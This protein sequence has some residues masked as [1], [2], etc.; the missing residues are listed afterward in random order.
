M[1]ATKKE[2][3]VVVTFQQNT[4]VTRKVDNHQRIQPPISVPSQT[5]LEGYNFSKSG[6]SM[7]QLLALS[8]NLVSKKEGVT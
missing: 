2:S 1:F 4:H 8:R 3:L 7:I 6:P 5:F